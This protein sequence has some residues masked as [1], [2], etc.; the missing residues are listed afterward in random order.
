MTYFAFWDIQEADA[1]LNSKMITSVSP[2]N[3]FS[4]DQNCDCRNLAIVYGEL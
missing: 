2:L 1:K 3:I 4:A